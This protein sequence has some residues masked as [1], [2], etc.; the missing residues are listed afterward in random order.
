MRKPGTINCM[1]K[2]IVG[3]FTPE[4]LNAYLL[5][6]FAAKWTQ[7]G[8]ARRKARALIIKCFRVN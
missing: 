3:N 8:F 1:Q 4:M 6:L 7:A 2:A 5:E